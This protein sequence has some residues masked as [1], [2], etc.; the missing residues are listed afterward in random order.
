V[1]PERF[2]PIAEQTGMIIELGNYILEQSLITLQSWHDRGVSLPH[3]S[4]NISMRQFLHNG[5]VDSVRRLIDLHLRQELHSKLMFEI[6]ESIVAEDINNVVLRMQELKSMGISFSMDD[7]GTGYSSLSN[8][9]R[10]P[11]SEIKLDRAFVAEIEHQGSDQALI[12]TILSMARMFHFSVVAE[13]VETAGQFAF[14]VEN[15]CTIF[16]GFNFSRPLSKEDFE[17]F[18][19][20]QS[21]RSAVAELPAG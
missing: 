6:T 5:F 20:R 9:K 4:I 3:L 7:F 16:Q 15:G 21:Y 1:P 14:L 10:L 18:Y 17:Q 19:F 8:V 11:I 2:I 12:R 13:G